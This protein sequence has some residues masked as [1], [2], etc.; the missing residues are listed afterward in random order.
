MGSAFFDSV[1]FLRYLLPFFFFFFNDTATTEIYTLSLHDALP[2]FDQAGQTF[3][4]FVAE[5]PKPVGPVQARQGLLL[6]VAR[7]AGL[8]LLVHE[9][10]DL[11]LIG[12]EA[13]PPLLVVDPD[14]ADPGLGSD[15]RD[16]VVD[17]V[18]VVGEHAVT[19]APL[20]RLANAVRRGK[21]PLFEI[22]AV[23]ECVLPADEPENDPQA[24]DK[25]DDEFDA[26]AA[27]EEKPCA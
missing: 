20:D 13:D 11:V 27:G 19:G 22:P 12:R 9:V 1:L 8:D 23:K 4:L 16:D 26:Q 14:A 18:P 24:C 21:R 17:L 10:P 7:D 25:V 2:I 5:N 6:G 15:R 3:P